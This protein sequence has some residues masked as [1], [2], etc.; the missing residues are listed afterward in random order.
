MVLKDI[1]KN[2][3]RVTNIVERMDGVLSHP[4]VS[5]KDVSDVLKSLLR[6]GFIS[7]EQYDVLSEDDNLNLDK[8]I[9]VIKT[10]KIGRGINFLPRETSDLQKKLCD[11]ATSY[12]D[13][14]QPDLKGNIMAALHEL[15]FQKVLT[16]RGYNDILKDMN[17]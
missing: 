7:K 15:R 13:E 10:T 12:P 8:V 2:R 16:K 14:Q 11:W 3:Y 6:E 1:F 5:A 9:S 17:K 4:N